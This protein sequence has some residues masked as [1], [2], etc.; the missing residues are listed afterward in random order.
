MIAR[1]RAGH[2]KLK[3]N[4]SRHSD[5]SSLYQV[6][7]ENSYSNILKNMSG[8]DIV[9]DAGANIGIFTL[10][11]SQVA[12]HVVAIEPDPQNYKILRE[13]VEGNGIENV[14]LIEKA[15]YS[16]SG[17]KMR[18]WQNGVMSKFSEEGQVDVETETLDDIA[19]KLDLHPTAIKMDIEGAEKFALRGMDRSLETVRM[20]QAEIHDGESFK[21]LG[22]KL[23]GF[24]ISER[25]GQEM[26]SVYAYVLKHP[27]WT[28]RLETQNNF[29]TTRRILKREERRQTAEFPKIVFA[30]RGG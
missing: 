14:T 19:Q 2:R 23:Q 15:L 5:F 28:L 29:L 24:S 16:S 26:L 21:I 4:L 6:F 9:V 13:N 8:N 25:N 22:E 20:V 12:E 11:A 1:I 17:Q 30:S 3:I 7:V 10:I 18:F 27:I